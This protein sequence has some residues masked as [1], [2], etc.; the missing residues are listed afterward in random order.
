[1]PE[2][3]QRLACIVVHHQ[4]PTTLPLTVGD[5]IASGVPAAQ[6]CVVDNSPESLP[7]VDPG[8]PGVRVLRVPNRG[9]GAAVNTATDR[10]DA[11]VTPFVLVCTHEVRISPGSVAALVGVLEAQPNAAAVGP[12][13]TLSEDARLWSQGGVLSRSLKVP[14]HRRGQPAGTRPVAVDWLDGACVL[15]RT[16]VLQR[17]RFDERYFLYFEETDLHVRLNRAGRGVLWVPQA[18]ASQRSSGIPPRL[19]GRNLLLFS[20]A[21]FS[22]RRGRLAVAYVTLRALAKSVLTRQGFPGDARAIVLGWRE[23]EAMLKGKR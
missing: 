9:Y 11:T 23:G 3:R 13:L 16:D 6:V 21:H 1:M 22:K 12:T 4:S 15:Y 8:V 17:F 10:L 14:V 20:A 2:S 18:E 19:L 7:D 5:L